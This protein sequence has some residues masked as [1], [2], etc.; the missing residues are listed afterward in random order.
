[1]RKPPQRGPRVRKKFVLSR[2]N[3]IRDLWSVAPAYRGG[4]LGAH[5]IEDAALGRW[6][7]P[8]VLDDV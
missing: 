5:V 7:P 8:I 6:A 1:M 2:H 4:P 3:M